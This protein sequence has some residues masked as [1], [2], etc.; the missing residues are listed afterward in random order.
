M[1]IFGG[2]LISFTF[3]LLKLLI[4]QTP[5]SSVAVHDNGI[6]IRHLWVIN[7]VLFFGE[8][9]PLVIQSRQSGTQVGE[10]I[11]RGHSFGQLIGK[12]LLKLGTED[13]FEQ[14]LISSIIK[15][16]Y[17]SL[18]EEF[19]PLN[20]SLEVLNATFQQFCRK[21]FN[22]GFIRYAT[23]DAVFAVEKTTEVI[24]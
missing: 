10:G 2:T 16:C 7:R 24:I 20:E 21:Y 4:S 13:R 11:W 17:N 22:N 8:I 15:N 9:I 19:M 3:I 5:S 12:I 14:G 6:T 23:S 18:S 1:S